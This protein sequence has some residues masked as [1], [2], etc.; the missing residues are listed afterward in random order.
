[1]SPSERRPRR[2]SSGLGRGA[3][4]R[5]S[6]SRSSIAARASQAGTSFSASVILVM[7]LACTGISLYDLYLLI[8]HL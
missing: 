3:G 4:S 1:M 7:I 5:A 8:S 6:G 2:D